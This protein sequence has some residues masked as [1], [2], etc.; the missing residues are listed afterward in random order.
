MYKQSMLLDIRLLWNWVRLLQ[1]FG[2]LP[3]AVWEMWRRTNRNTH[4]DSYADANTYAFSVHIFDLFA[5]IFLLNHLVQLHHFST[6]PVRHFNC[7]HKRPLRQL[8]YLCRFFIWKLLLRVVLV[9]EWT[10]LL[11]Y[12]VP[13]R[14]RNLR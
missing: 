7:F 1:R 11:R 13:L 12:R 8:H 10:G 14:L 4:T 9:R 3:A 2:G 6:A 5:A